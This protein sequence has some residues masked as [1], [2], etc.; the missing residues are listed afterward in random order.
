MQRE[1]EVAG[2]VGAAP[3][4]CPVPAPAPSPSAASSFLTIFGLELRIPWLALSPSSFSSS[5]ARPATAFCVSRISH[6][7]VLC[8]F[9][10]FPLPLFP[11]LLFFSSCFFSLSFCSARVLF[12]PLFPA[13]DFHF[14]CNF[15]CLPHATQSG[16]SDSA[17]F[18]VP[19]PR[20]TL[21]PSLLLSFSQP[22]YACCNAS[23]G[24]LQLHLQGRILMS[25]LSRIRSD[26]HVPPALCLSPYS[27]PP[28]CPIFIYCPPSDHDALC[29]NWAKSEGHSR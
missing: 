23:V 2:D 19:P 18:H 6:P 22:A 13:L 12:T 26:A 24:R 11:P 1:E 15:I 4:G 9:F 8:V 16:H 3:F 27:L 28:L 10:L 14:H 21:S 20:P 7:S 25:L 29:G 5:P 17:P